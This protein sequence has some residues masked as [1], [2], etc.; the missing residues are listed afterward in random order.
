MK[1][2]LKDILEKGT[3]EG[4]SDIHL[5]AG[6]APMHVKNG[7]VAPLGIGEAMGNEEVR[8]LLFSALSPK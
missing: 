6:L 1:E 8:E 7:K 2:K 4:A 3:A 5:K